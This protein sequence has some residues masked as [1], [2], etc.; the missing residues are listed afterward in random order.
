MVLQTAVWD[1]FSDLNAD[2]AAGRV[3]CGSG[4]AALPCPLKL[5]TPASAFAKSSFC[6]SSDSGTGMYP[7]CAYLGYGTVANER[8]T[9]PDFNSTS[10]DQLVSA[11]SMHSC[12]LFTALPR[13]PAAQMQGLPVLSP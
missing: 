12:V 11:Y 5:I 9:F 13:R 1:A 10:P 8:T 2:Y 4:S 7:P 6:T 3:A